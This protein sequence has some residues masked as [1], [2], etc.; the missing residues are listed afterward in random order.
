MILLYNSI[1]TTFTKIQ[2]ESIV[3]CFIQVAY[4]KDLNIINTSFFS[5]ITSC[6]AMSI[7]AYFASNNE[8]E[9]LQNFTISAV[10]GLLAISI[11][12]MKVHYF[13]VSKTAKRALELEKDGL[14]I[15]K[16]FWK[17]LFAI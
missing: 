13:A 1:M 10:L 3:D 15:K 6:V 9:F 8:Q 17:K 2:K 5:T 14:Q 4:Q 7:Y 16:S 12:A 11:L